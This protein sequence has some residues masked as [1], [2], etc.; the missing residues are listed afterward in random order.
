MS[1]RVGIDL[2]GTSVKFGIVDETF[3]IIEKHSIPTLAQRT[4]EEIVKDIALATMD[5]LTKANLILDEVEYIGIGVPSSVNPLTKK[6][7]FANN[8]NWKDVDFIKEFNKT[9]N[10]Q[11]YIANDA[12]CAAYGEVLAGAA[13]DNDNA[14]MLTL[15]TGVGGGMIIDGKIYLGGNGFGCEFGHALLKMGGEKCTCGRNGCVEAYASVTAL[16]RD[17]KEAIKRNPTS[18]MNTIIDNDLSKVEGRTCFDAAEKNDATAIE[19]VNQYIEYLAESVASLINE[20]R[21]KT[22]ILGGGV[23]NQKEKLLVPLKAR[24]NELVY[25]V[26]YIGLPNV[27]IAK[28]GNDAGIIGAAMLGKGLN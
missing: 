7:V 17:T 5:T 25:G 26:E 19:V 2:G 9:I 27:V 1:Y 13:Q 6:I 12:D 11:I 21:P 3:N 4:F 8:L 14:V 18:L 23:S 20:L 15:G 28:L 10:K 16:I 22:V 24:L